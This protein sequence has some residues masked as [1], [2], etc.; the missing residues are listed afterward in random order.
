[1]PAD[2]SIVTQNRA[3]VFTLARSR[4]ALDVSVITTITSTGPWRRLPATAPAV[5]GA[6]PHPRR[7]Q[8]LAV[9]DLARLLDL[10]QEAVAPQAE[11]TV[12]LVELPR[13]S[14][15]LHVRQVLAVSPLAG[16][17]PGGGDEPPWVAGYLPQDGADPASVIDTATLGL[18][19]DTLRCVRDDPASLSLSATA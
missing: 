8:A 11:R 10:P 1:M 9:V 18:L 14:C 16:L 5:L 17:Q 19:L 6:M 15:A 3:C 13:L 4:F 7:P 2:L 12:L